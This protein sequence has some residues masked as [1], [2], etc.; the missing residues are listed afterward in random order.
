LKVAEFNR[1]ENL[2]LALIFK[3]QIGLNDFFTGEQQYY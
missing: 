3:K 1:Y 2:T